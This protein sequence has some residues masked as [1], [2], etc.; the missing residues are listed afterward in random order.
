VRCI[1]DFRVLRSSTL[2]L[3]LSAWQLSDWLL[4]L[5]ISRQVL[6][7][8]H[9]VRCKVLSLRGLLSAGRNRTLLAKDRYH[10]LSSR[11]G[12]I[13]V[14]VVGDR[15]DPTGRKFVAI[16]QANWR[17]IWRSHLITNLSLR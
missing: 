15:L 14:A 12:N 9:A 7:P 3:R 1:T 16:I 17:G 11:S 5:A 10:A 8:W 2:V 4:I 13:F 6:L